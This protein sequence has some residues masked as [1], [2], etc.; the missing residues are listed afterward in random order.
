MD[1]RFRLPQ[2][3]CRPKRSRGTGN[4]YWQSCIKSRRRLRNAAEKR[5]VNKRRKMI[6]I[7][8]RNREKE[9]L[10]GVPDAS[11][12]A[13]KNVE[14]L[15]GYLSPFLFSGRSGMLL[16]QGRVDI[17]TDSIQFFLIIPI[18]IIFLLRF[19]F[20]Y[21]QFFLFCFQCL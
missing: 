17:S 12:F 11:F 20:L 4:R 1:I 13:P 8:N 7:G 10:A 15:S 2:T 5:N 21:Q 16:S 3:V 6:W 9:C 19:F 14:S 18:V